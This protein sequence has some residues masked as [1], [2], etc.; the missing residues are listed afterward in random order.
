MFLSPVLSKFAIEKN[1]EN[2]ATITLSPPLAGAKTPAK[3]RSFS[4]TATHVK[5]PFAPTP[6]YSSY[7]NTSSMVRS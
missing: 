7:R 5:S 3:P 6:V 4:A 1:E 2:M